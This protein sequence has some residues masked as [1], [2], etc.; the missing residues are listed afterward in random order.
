MEFLRPTWEYHEATYT[1]TELTQSLNRLGKD[2]WELVSAF[3]VKD[4]SLNRVI[5]KRQ[6]GFEEV[7]EK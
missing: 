5:L 7:E 4:S 6:V 1:T 3:L 2:G